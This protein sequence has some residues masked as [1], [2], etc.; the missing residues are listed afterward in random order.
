[1]S[2]TKRKK[3]LHGLSSDSQVTLSV[4]AVSFLF[5]TLT[6]SDTPLSDTLLSDTPRSSSHT[7]AAP[8]LY[9]PG[10]LD[11]IPV[12]L[13][14][15]IFADLSLRD[16]L[17]LQLVSR[18]YNFISRKHS[19]YTLHYSNPDAFHANIETFLDDFLTLSP[20]TS[21]IKITTIGS[22][23]S[24]THLSNSSRGSYHFHTLWR[25]T[26]CQEGGLSLQ[27]QSRA[28]VIEPLNS[29]MPT[30]RRLIFRPARRDL[31]RL[32]L[33]ILP[34][35]TTFHDSFVRQ[36]PT[37]SPPTPVT[38]S[39]VPPLNPWRLERILTSFTRAESK[40]HL[41]RPI[42][43][44]RSRAPTRT[45]VLN[46][47]RARVGM[48]VTRR[49]SVSLASPQLAT[50]AF[51]AFRVRSKEDEKWRGRGYD[52]T[53]TEAWS[54]AVEIV[55]EARRCSEAAEK[56]KWADLVEIEEEEEEE[57]ESGWVMGTWYAW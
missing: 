15:Q 11:I 23:I 52:I 57:E 7:P 51:T 55:E 6:L 30:E 49:A 37:A 21:T 43:L 5:S 14:N 56:G 50:K 34:Q 54:C 33:E 31:H 20:G 39:H 28:A 41:G 32:R 47:Q 40:L 38:E 9:L 22:L 16:H 10:S 26:M 18:R 4:D 29:A 42:S 46:T 24:P 36:P 48:V 12:E 44:H 25:A 2:I 53:K 3:H 19:V 8:P 13:I 17:A 35:D 45:Y 1:M 27:I